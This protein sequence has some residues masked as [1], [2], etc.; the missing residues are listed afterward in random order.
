VWVSKEAPYLH[1]AILVL[2]QGGRLSYQ[3]A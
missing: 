2:P 1:Q 3:P